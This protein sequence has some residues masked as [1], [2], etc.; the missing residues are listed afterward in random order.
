MGLFTK[1]AAKIPPVVKQGAKDAQ[2]G[3]KNYKVDAF[4]QKGRDAKNDKDKVN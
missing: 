1:V 2:Q 4:A 3:K